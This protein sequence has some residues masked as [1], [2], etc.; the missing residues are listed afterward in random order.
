MRFSSD[1][2][3]QVQNA[4]NIVD[5]IGTYIGL[6]PAGGDRW[7]GLCPFPDH[8]EKTPSFSVS[9]DKQVFHCFGC[10]KSGNI[11]HF[12][13]DLQ[14]INFP[15]AVEHL[16]DRA[17]LSLPREFQMS[18]HQRHQKKD[19]KKQAWEVNKI[20][21]RFFHRE[22]LSLSPTHPAREYCALRGLSNEM[23]R[24]FCIGYAPEGWENLHQHLQEKDIQMAHSLG[25]LKE[26]VKG[27]GG[28]FYDLFRN[29]LMFPIVGPMNHYVGF[30]GRALGDRPPKYLNSPESFVF[31]KGKILYGL[32]WVAKYIRTESCAIVVEG[33]MDFMALQR[34]GIRNVVATLGTALTED[35]S[36]Q[37][38][39]LT[40]KVVV[41]FDG[42]S[43]GQEASQRSLPLLLGQGLHPRVCV[44]ENG[45]DPDDF[46][47]SEGI[48]SLK[49]ALRASRDLFLGHLENLISKV[50]LREISDKVLILDQLT[51]IYSCV[52]DPRL[53]DLY[54]I[55]ISRLLSAEQGWVRRSLRSRRKPPAQEMPQKQQKEPPEKVAETGG[56]NKTDEVGE[57]E[58][59]FVLRGVPK[60]EIYLLNLALMT[61]E[62]FVTIRDTGVVEQFSH[63][64]VCEIFKWAILEHRQGVRQFD[65]LTASLASKVDSPR[66]VSLYLEKPISELDKRGMRR[67][68]EDCCR[69]VRDK[70][71]IAQTKKLSHRLESQTTAQQLEQLERIVNIHRDRHRLKGDSTP[72]LG[73]ESRK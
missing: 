7:M 11:Y 50:G 1:F 25:L 9:E 3:E 44:L 24:E 70:F 62:Q 39:R 54:L 10:K 51:P 5:I 37:L 55:E 36:R 15:E 41:L 40:Q 6:K 68:I 58:E 19:E 29:R 66:E 21:A 31:Q 45:Q 38:R 43:A 57:M 12:L 23:I 27:S 8:N 52:T 13:R 67:L 4:N 46:L 18:S 26:R 28:G 17:G 33:Y 69:K 32:S 22:L 59:V 48:E 30:G 65:S 72:S 71:L 73:I 49:S 60:E 34:A 20:A 63:P 64:A 16:A 35:H 53:R 61:E 47:K 14:G 42:D 2:I 56:A